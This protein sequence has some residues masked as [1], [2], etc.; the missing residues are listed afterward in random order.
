MA[1]VTFVFR[2]RKCREYVLDSQCVVTI[3]GQQYP[4]SCGATMM[5]SDDSCTDVA[6]ETVWYINEESAPAWILKAIKTA[7]WTKGKLHCPKCGGRLGSFNFTKTVKCACAEFTVPPVHILQGR[8]DLITPP[9][10]QVSEQGRM[11]GEDTEQNHDMLSEERNVIN[12][13]DNPQLTANPQQQPHGGRSLSHKVTKPEAC[14]ESSQGINSGPGQGHNLLHDSQSHISASDQEFYLLP[15]GQGQ[16]SVSDQGH[17]LLS[18]GQ[19]HKSVA[20]QGVYLLSKGQGHSLVSDQS[21]N[22][23][24]EGQGHTLVSDQDHNLLPEGQGHSSV[25]DQEHNFLPEGQGHTLLSDQE[26]NL[27][28]EGQG[29]TLVS[30]QDHNLLPEGQG[31]SSV[32]DQEHNFLPEGQ[33]HTLVSDQEHNFLPE[34]QGHTLLSDQEHNLLPEG[35]GHTLVSDQEHNLLSESQGHTLVSDQ[36]HNL[37]SVDLGLLEISDDPGP[38]TTEG[39]EGSQRHK[40]SSGR[41]NH[42]NG[43][44]RGK[45]N[46]AASRADHEENE[47]VDPVFPEEHTCP[48]CF[49]LYCHPMRTSPCGHIFCE[50]CLR[51]LAKTKPVKTPCPLCRQV[52]VKCHAEEKFARDL[53]TQYT[54]LYK[55]RQSMERKF[56]NNSFHRLPEINSSVLRLPDRLGQDPWQPVRQR[57][58][59]WMRM[60]LP[61]VH[62]IHMYVTLL[63]IVLLNT[64]QRHRTVVL[65]ACLFLLTC[66]AVPVLVFLSNAVRVIGSLSQVLG[67]AVVEHG[68]SMVISPSVEAFQSDSTQNLLP[69]SVRI[70]ALTA[71]FFLIVIVVLVCRYVFFRRVMIQLGRNV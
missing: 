18:E 65:M 16:S 43:H 36:G 28:P 41:F 69:T 15:V 24:P 47:D 63:V 35:Q 46:S 23:L 56:H 60:L 4:V 9:V 32:S 12:K 64:L 61:S 20:D 45:R 55:K 48:I 51:R 13:G 6:M 1:G 54:G 26:H 14:S 44:R 10:T 31:H 3:H 59:D 7:L 66:L 22:L 8:V 27:L 53:K 58:N 39:S 38:S 21:H 25:S 2:C 29:H 49:D 71:N 70:R 17:N 30:E 68:G 40:K 37:L 42:K 67:Q 57:N 34:G 19:G 52:I 33:G 50:M 62:N 11:R 5:P